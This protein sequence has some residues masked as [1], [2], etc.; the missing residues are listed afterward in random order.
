MQYN[1]IQYNTIQG[2]LKKCTVVLQLPFLEMEMVYVKVLTNWV[3]TQYLNEDAN[4]D[5]DDNDGD[6][7]QGGGQ[8][9][10]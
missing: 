9:K 3:L 5:Q 10:Q 8:L 7:E 4:A 1:A 2:N 6:R